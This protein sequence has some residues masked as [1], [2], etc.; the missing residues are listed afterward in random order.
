MSV[1]EVLAD[2]PDLERDDL[3]EALELAAL[4]TGGQAVGPRRHRSADR[5]LGRPAR[6]GNDDLLKLFE[7]RLVEIEEAFT[8]AGVHPVGRSL[9]GRG[10]VR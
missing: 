1:E 10:F 7:S 9:P 6:S 3:L 5:G 4:T 8:L 2:Y